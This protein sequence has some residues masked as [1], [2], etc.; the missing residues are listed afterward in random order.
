MGNG[1]KFELGGKDLIISGLNKSQYYYN[2]DVLNMTTY[3]DDETKIRTSLGVQ[4][5]VEYLEI[6]ICGDNDKITHIK[7]K[8]YKTFKPYL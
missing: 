6:Y 8:G 4:V 5:T 7:R 3:G 1:I 2:D